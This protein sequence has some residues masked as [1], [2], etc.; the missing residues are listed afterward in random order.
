M[1]NKKLSILVVFMLL[2]SCGY[3]PIFSS[4]ES[5]FSINKIELAEKNNINSKIKNTLKVY[6]K[7]KNTKVFYDFL[8][9]IDKYGSQHKFPRVLKGKL[10]DDWE[11]Y[12]AIVEEEKYHLDIKT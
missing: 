11:R 9:L 10:A 8:K 12:I 2:L 7:N 5:S 6:K 4:G 3:Q 1:I